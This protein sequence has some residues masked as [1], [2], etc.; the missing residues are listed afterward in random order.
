MALESVVTN[1]ARSDDEYEDED[2]EADHNAND[3]FDQQIDQ[4]SSN[5]NTS[6]G[7]LL[8]ASAEGS[9]LIYCFW[10]SVGA[11][12]GDI[13]F[14]MATHRLSTAVA[15]LTSY[16][17]MGGC[18]SG[19]RHP[20]QCIN[21][22]VGGTLTVAEIETGI[23]IFGK[24][25]GNG[26]SYGGI[27]I[28]SGFRCDDDHIGTHYHS[29]S[30]HTDPWA[31]AMYE[32]EADEHTEVN[33]YM[34]QKLFTLA[35][36]YPVE[37]RVIVMHDQDGSR[38][39]CGKIATQWH[40]YKWSLISILLFVVQIIG[41]MAFQSGGRRYRFSKRRRYNDAGRGAMF[42]ASERSDLIWIM[43]TLLPLPFFWAV[44]AQQ[45]L[46]WKEQARH[47]D[48]SWFP[49][50][51]RIPQ[52][53]QLPDAMGTF[54]R[55][56]VVLLVFLYKILLF[57]ALNGVR[58]VICNRGLWAKERALDSSNIGKWYCFG[59]ALSRIVWGFVCLLAAIV[60]AERLQKEIDARPQYEDDLYDDDDDNVYTPT[61][62]VKYQ[63]AQ[64]I[65]LGL[66]EVLV[67]T[68]GITYCY[69][70]ME[71]SL[72]ATM[73][74]VWVALWIGQ[75]LGSLT[76]E[77]YPSLLVGFDA[78]AVTIAVVILWFGFHAYNHT[79]KAERLSRARII[80]EASDHMPEDHLLLEDPSRY[81][82]AP[83]TLEEEE[84][85]SD[86]DFVFGVGDF[87]GNS[88]DITGDSRNFDF[89]FDPAPL[90]REGDPSSEVLE[91]DASH[92][93]LA[94]QAEEVGRS[95]GGKTNPKRMPNRKKSSSRGRGVVG[96][97]KSTK[98]DA[99]E[100]ESDAYD[101]EPGVYLK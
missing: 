75:L 38:I 71:P 101:G 12:L 62:N 50:L 92:V 47:L 14:R 53:W 73:E 26:M 98:R 40:R 85:D 74:G 9:L 100:E 32:V 16:P 39:S 86:D 49:F 87:Y 29:N 78:S 46:M 21:D 36:E 35:G 20:I 24:I 60:S 70:E 31:N 64:T 72:R 5:I 76:Y 69:D 81:R 91:V 55:L 82:R 58:V 18:Q 13:T 88:T 65:F 23:E 17:V 93:S 4:G 57:P 96:S 79:P 28:H 42:T 61:I 6:E 45:V 66:S 68:A 52:S 54:R 90:D 80:A 10:A 56:V 77:V 51:D 7:R 95:R 41:S 33:I 89:Q 59:S 2:D 67:V 48:T 30:P 27:H 25:T 43:P 1:P 83:G 3:S 22:G 34:K 11:L 99:E 44:Y 84:S 8:R 94:V 37:G 19:Q 63:L 15:D 97:S